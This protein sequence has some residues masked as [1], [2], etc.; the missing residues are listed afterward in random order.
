MVPFGWGA[1]SEL[2]C[3]DTEKPFASSSDGDI[4]LMHQ[5][6]RVSLS[7]SYQEPRPWL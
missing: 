6:T 5:L 7:F 3:S 2:L 1:P 4:S